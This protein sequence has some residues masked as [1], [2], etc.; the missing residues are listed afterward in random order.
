MRHSFI[1]FWKAVCTGHRF[2]RAT[3]SIYHRSLFLLGKFW[4]PW[5]VCSNRL[6]ILWRHEIKTPSGGQ[7]YKAEVITGESAKKPSALDRH[8]FKTRVSPVEDS[9]LFAVNVGKHSGSNPH[10]LYTRESTLEKGFM[11]L[12]NVKNLL[13]KAQPSVNM[14]K[15]ILVQYRTSAANV[16]N[17]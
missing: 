11:Y 3:H 17:L 13:D 10:L 7:L 6:L 14:E 5:D 4:P 2:L 1:Y 16:E 8:L 15:F 9:V 12:A